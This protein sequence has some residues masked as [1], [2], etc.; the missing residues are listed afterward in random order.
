MI[1][2]V[3]LEDAQTLNM[4]LLLFTIFVVERKYMK[5][6]IKLFL[7]KN[8]FV[9]EGVKSVLC[10]CFQALKIQIFSF[11]LFTNEKVKMWRRSLDSFSGST[12][13]CSPELVT[14]LPFQSVFLMSVMCDI[15][16]VNVNFVIQNL[17]LAFP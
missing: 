17:E 6:R 3:W 12:N 5:V 1:N 11:P 13:N 16:N 2:S 9:G 8:V 7:T 14:G 15:Q 10:Y 4:C